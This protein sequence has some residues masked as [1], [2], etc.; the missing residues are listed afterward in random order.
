MAKKYKDSVFKPID[1][2]KLRTYSIRKRKH[3]ISLK[4][5]VRLTKPPKGFNRW[6][7]R[8]PN[9]LA[10][11]D[12][13][14]LINAIVKAYKNRRMIGVGLGAHIIKCGLSPI[15]IDLMKRGIV[16][17]VAMHGA[18]A[19]HDYEISLI[20]A[21]SEDVTES[22]PKGKFGMA[23]ETAQA[24]AR[25]ASQAVSKDIGLGRAFGNLIRADKNPYANYSILAQ[26]A[27][28]NLPTT[29]HIAL[30]TDTVHMHPGVSGKDLGESSLYDFRLFTSVICNLNKGVWLNLG[31]AVILPEVFLKAFSI[32]RNLGRRLDDFTT[33]NLDMIQHYRGRINVTGRPTTKGINLTGHHEIMLPLL[34]WG[35][36]SRLPFTPLEIRKS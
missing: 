27:K 2:R 7:D 6:L 12:F 31:S 3:R 35:I 23:K 25:A 9:L 10:S 16:K 11:Q 4:Q 13:N 24:F 34:Y 20:G 36:L 14:R 28:M 26:A 18:T 29:I 8:L 21:S 32:A 5:F 17:A 33:A 19:I 15:I 30:G 1:L 22:L